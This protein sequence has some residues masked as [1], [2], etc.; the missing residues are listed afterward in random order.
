MSFRYNKGESLVKAGEFI[1][2]AIL[3]HS[4]FVKVH[5]EYKR[6]GIIF[7]IIGPGKFIALNHMVSLDLQPFDI[8]A[9]DATSVCMTDISIYRQ[10]LKQTISLQI[11][12]LIHLIKM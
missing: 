5:L 1:N 9:I 3:I 10:I 8:T 4:G 12:C 7:S 6:R 2:N 11:K